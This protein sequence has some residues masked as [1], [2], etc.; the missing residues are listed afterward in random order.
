[1]REKKHMINLKQDIRFKVLVNNI[2]VQ[3]PG[4]CFYT[5]SSETCHDSTDLQLSLQEDKANNAI[6]I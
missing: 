1:M 4:L 6:D 3:L 2:N 5:S